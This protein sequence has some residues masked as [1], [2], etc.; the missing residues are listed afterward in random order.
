MRNG[1]TVEASSRTDSSYAAENVLAE[2]GHGSAWQA[3]KIEDQYLVFDF[4][5]AVE[6]SGFKMHLDPDPSCPRICVLENTDKLHA[7]RKWK[8]KWNRVTVW[9]E[10]RFS[11]GYESGWSIKHCFDKRVAR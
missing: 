8:N 2:D 5:T 11:S 3:G 4:A 1:L 6:L 10:D 7:T 9:S